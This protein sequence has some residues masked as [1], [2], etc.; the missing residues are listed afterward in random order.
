MPLFLRAHTIASP[1]TSSRRCGVAGADSSSSPPPLS[2]PCYCQCI[3]QV[4]HVG[5]CLSV[6]PG[7]IRSSIRHL[8]LL[9]LLQSICKKSANITRK[10]CTHTLIDLKVYCQHLSF[11]QQHRLAW[12]PSSA[13]S[14]QDPR[15]SRH[16]R[17]DSGGRGARETTLCKQV[18][19]LPK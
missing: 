14:G 11:G 16:D 5:R 7:S 19:S 12:P 3:Q 18:V 15:L 8:L 2:L 10:S 4:Y 17:L 9:P 13:T 6:V 1:P